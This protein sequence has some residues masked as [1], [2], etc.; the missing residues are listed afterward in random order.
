M[1][2]TGSVVAGSAV[3]VIGPPL[4]RGLVP[5]HCGVVPGVVRAHVDQDGS[6]LI[7]GARS[8][9]S[10]MKRSMKSSIKRS[11]RRSMKR[12]SMK[13]RKNTGQ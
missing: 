11:R 13:R 4:P 1:S 7:L 9:R 5:D 10:S 8:G 2:G 3:V 12:R 6:E